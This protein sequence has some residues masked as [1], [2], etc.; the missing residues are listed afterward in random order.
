MNKYLPL[1]KMCIFGKRPIAH[2]GAVKRNKP[3]ETD[4]PE[5]HR[6]FTEGRKT[7]LLKGGEGNKLMR[8]TTTEKF[9]PCS[10]LL[11]TQEEV[12]MVYALLNYVPIVEL[13]DFCDPDK[14]RD[15]LKMIYGNT[16][17]YTTCFERVL[18]KLSTHKP[19]S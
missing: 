3:I 7:I 18:S 15:E 10:L 9:K 17:D 2:N 8:V 16:I 14:V 5:T 19:K 11:E 1:A 12:E 6:L 4:F 13:L